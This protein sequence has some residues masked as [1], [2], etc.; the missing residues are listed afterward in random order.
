MN[1]IGKK[2]F[3]FLASYGFATVLLFFLLLL[4]LFGTLEQVNLGLFEAQKKYFESIFLV[5]HL[6]GVIP[7][8]LPGAYLLMGLLFVNLVCGGIIRARKNWRQPGMLIT[9]GGIL[10]MLVAG[11]VTYHYSISGHM[12]LYENEQAA[13]FQ[14]YY[15]WEI[16]I[17][18]PGETQE[19]IVPGDRFTKLRPGETKT[20]AVAGLPVE[21]TLRD[22]ARNTTPQRVGPTVSNQV[23]GF[24]L[25]SMPLDKTAE[26]NI[27]GAYATLRDPNTGESQEG[28]LWGLAQA[29]WNATIGGEQYLVDLRHKRYPV[30]FTITLD[31]FTRELHPGTQMAASFS[32]DVTQMEET[33]A[34]RQIHI[35]MNEPLR[36][37]GFTFFQA[38]WGPQ[39]A[40]PNDRLFSTFAVVNNPADQ[41]PL[42]ACYVITVG[43]LIHFGQKMVWY[44]KRENRR[45]AA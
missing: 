34:T 27:A 8:P 38:S 7:L 13:E 29:P 12:T 43:L 4:T 37:R 44:I 10:F 9:H 14:S 19:W 31:K 3:L 35:R 41:W 5:H 45:R 16:G 2:I 40:G 28:L 23:S 32:S 20:F 33:G 15:E 24:N 36:D 30:P 21:L 39:G 11:F 17:T 26:R 42:Y 22:Y 1:T 18:K 25:V 6:F